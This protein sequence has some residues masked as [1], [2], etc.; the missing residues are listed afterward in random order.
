MNDN[1]SPADYVIQ[2]NVDQSRA[3]LSIIHVYIYTEE[4]D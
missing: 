1:H 4:K 3:S 2:V